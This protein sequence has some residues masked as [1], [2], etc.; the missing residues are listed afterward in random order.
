M[1]TDHL[2]SPRIATDQAGQVVSCHDYM[3]F[4]EEIYAGVG[5]RTAGMKYSLTTA[6]HVRQRFT[7]YEKDDETGLDFAQ[8]R[9]YQNRHGRF[10]APD[11][12]LA[13]ADGTNPQTFNRYSYTGNNPINYIDPSGLRWCRNSST[14][15][16]NYTPGDAPCTGEGWA[17]AN[18]SVV[19]IKSGDW[20][21]EK[22]NVGDTVK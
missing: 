5:G 22:A 4:G 21:K 10:T 17:D 18:N 2:G 1:T 7:G 9:M 15:A 3:P 12:L 11:P 19:T 8:A 14:G 6:D 16:T 20:S 13:S